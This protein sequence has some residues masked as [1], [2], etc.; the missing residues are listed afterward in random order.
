M[1]TMKCRHC[2]AQAEVVTTSLDGDVD[3]KAVCDCGGVTYPTD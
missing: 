3:R 1:E 2:G